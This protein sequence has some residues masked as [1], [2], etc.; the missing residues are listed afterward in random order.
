LTPPVPAALGDAFDALDRCHGDGPVD[1]LRTY[2]AAVAAW[3]AAADVA[4]PLAEPLGQCA[5]G[6]AGQLAAGRSTVPH[7]VL[8]DAVPPSRSRLARLGDPAE[9]LH[10]PAG[11]AVQ[12][13]EYP[14]AVELARRWHPPVG[15][16]RTLHVVGLSTGGAYLAPVVAAALPRDRVATE[17]VRPG[18]QL[19][20]FAARLRPERDRVLLVDDPPL[21]GTTLRTVVEGLLDVAAVEILVP[22][23]ELE[24]ADRLAISCGVPVLG[25]E[26]AA[27]TSTARLHPDR[28]A[29][30]LRGQVDWSPDRPDLTLAGYLV[31]FENSSGAPWPGLRRRSPARSAVYL[32]PS[33]PQNGGRLI[34]AAVQWIPAGI[35]GDT[36]RR[37]AADLNAPAVPRTLGVAHWAVVTEWRATKPDAELTDDVGWA[38]AQEYVHCR[39]RE[40]PL[41]GAALRHPDSD[42]TL[43]HIAERLGPA[44][45][46]AAAAWLAERLT[47]LP[48]C[49]PDNRLEREKWYLDA[50]GQPTKT[51]HLSHAGRRDNQW[52]S[53]L[54]DLAAACVAFRRPLSAL[55]AAIGRL[56]CATVSQT[57][58]EVT[59]I[60]AAAAS[61]LYYGAGRGR[62]LSRTFDPVHAAVHAREAWHL[63]RLLAEAAAMLGPDMPGRT[64]GWAG[65]QSAFD[66]L[67]D[68][69]PNVLVGAVVPQPVPLSLAPGA[70]TSSG[71]AIHAAPSERRWREFAVEAERQLRGHFTVEAAGPHRL[72]LI[73]SVP[74][75]RWGEA[76]QAI[77]DVMANAEPG[78]RCG[79]F[80]TPFLERT[81]S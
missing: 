78:I 53:P 22:V 70:R 34:P 79:W 73:P 18:P 77:A 64:D 25:L 52:F 26:R 28:L 15:D 72:L 55:T 14:D 56:S 24:D 68:Q 2:E 42:G 67:A 7:A 4:D 58:S 48:A 41:P 51:G 6:L 65:G 57:A 9:P 81:R 10:V 35:F 66:D 29:A 69:V 44:D 20:R 39:A 76:S 47:L 3:I 1:V 16:E 54:L 17:I 59:A 23:F 5:C 49:I 31:G 50:A 21:T 13:I 40:L 36:A 75:A 12:G 11:T 62:Q 8:A 80:G 45:A 74:I 33:G 19:A 27:W 30:A 71:S 43:R 37:V 46:A 60:E 63:Q 32:Q 38:S 61:M